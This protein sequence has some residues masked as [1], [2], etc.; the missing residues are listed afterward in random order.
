VRAYLDRH[1]FA[2]TTF[3]DL[4]RELET[5]SGRD[6]GAWATRG[7]APRREHPAGAGRDDVRVAQESTSCATHRI[8]VGLYD[9]QAATCVLRDRLEVDLRGGSTV[10]PLDPAD[11]PTCCCPTTATSP[12]PSSASTTGRSRRCCAR[13]AGCR[14]AGPAL[15]WAALWD[16]LRDA[17]LPRRRSSTRCWPAS[18]ARPTRGG[19]DAADA[20]A[21]RRL[22]LRA[23][24]RRCRPARAAPRSRPP[25]VE[26]GS[27]L[28]LVRARAVAAA[29]G[30]EHAGVLAGWLA[31][32]DVPP[33]LVV[34]TEL[35][36]S[37][38]EALA[39][40]AASTTRASTPSS[41]ATT[42]RP[43]RSTRAARAARPDAA[44]K[45]RAWTAA[46]QDLTLSNKQAEAL[47]PRLLAAGQDELL[48]P[49]VDRYVAAA[50]GSGR[51]GR[52]RWRRP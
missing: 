34:D 19:L 40:S 5:A 29:C 47:G 25:A 37:L 45:E 16:A 8:G 51:A 27:D 23:D 43:E 42:P 11:R 28:Q 35:R 22:A 12:S 49:Y 14:P 44:A 17:E 3:A 1:A 32:D 50:P 10:L 46:T 7:C 20:G 4:L 38:V 52:R 18:T 31:G 15:C 9:E 24:G 13:C 48:A 39:A 21:D 41:P 36:W 30:K 2:N 6:L 26:P 33:G